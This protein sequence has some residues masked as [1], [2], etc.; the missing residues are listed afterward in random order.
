[1]VLCCNIAIVTYK[2]VCSGH[3]VQ[4]ALPSVLVNGCFLVSLIIIPRRSLRLTSMGNC[5]VCVCVRACVR[6]CV[7]VGGCVCVCV[8]ACVCVCVRA[9]VCV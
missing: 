9:C 7:C 1:M 8:C 4:S 3:K 5:G 2:Y 6:V